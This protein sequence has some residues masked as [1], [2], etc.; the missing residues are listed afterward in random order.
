MPDR[1]LYQRFLFEDFPVRGALVHLHAS[2]QEVLVRHD[3]P[4]MIRDL[5]GELLAAAVLLSSTIKHEGSVTMQIQGDGPVNLLVA[6]Y[7]H[8]HTL[9]GVA[10]WQHVPDGGLRQLVGEGTFV[11][12]IDPGAGRRRYQSIVNI[13]GDT[14]AEVLQAYLN[15][16]EQLP[17]RLWLTGN[18]DSV[19]GMLLQ[20]MPDEQAEAEDWNRVTQLADTITPTELRQLTN[21]DMLYRLFHEENLRLFEPQ[22]VRFYCTCTRDKVGDMLRSLGDQELQSI[23]QEQGAVGVNC[24]FCNQHYEFDK[25]DIESLFAADAASPEVPPTRH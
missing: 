5:L 25:V 7:T 6:E 22:P 19:A 23:L 13:S 21:K 20:R 11:I 14:V 8:E 18:G 3:Y 10:S 17:T 24:Q 12:N 15:Q 2:W 9:R 4:P 1:D 16:S